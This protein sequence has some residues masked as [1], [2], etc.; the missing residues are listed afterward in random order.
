M[1]KLWLSGLFLLLVVCAVLVF[2]STTQTGLNWIYQLAARTLP[3]SLNIEALEGRLIGPLEFKSLNYRDEQ[4]TVTVDEGR[5]DWRPSMLL[6]RKL[7][8]TTITAEGITYVDTDQREPATDKDIQLPDVS[9]PLDIDVQSLRLSR[10]A[11]RSDSESRIDEITLQAQTDDERLS[12]QAFNLKSETF[13]VNLQGTVTTGDDY[14]LDLDLQWQLNSQS[15]APVS[16]NTLLK[17]SLA[18]LTIQSNMTGMATV[19]MQAAVKNVLTD[20]D[21]NANINIQRLEPNKVQ[22]QWPQTLISGEINTSGNLEAY[23]LAVSLTASETDKAD[24]ELPSITLAASANGNEAELF[25]TALRMA[26]LEGQLEGLG[27]V[28]WSP[29]LLWD[30]Q[31]TAHDINPGVYWDQWP[32]K[33]GMKAQIKGEQSGNTIINNVNLETLDGDLRGYPVHAQGQFVQLGNDLEIEALQAS[34]GSAKLNATGVLKKNWGLRWSLQADDLRAVVPDVRGRLD[35]QG[36]ITGLRQSPRAAFTVVGRDLEVAANRITKLDA[37]VD[38]DLSTG[39]KLLVQVDAANLILAEH[40]WQTSTLTLQG[41]LDKH[42]LRLRLNN[43]A[44]VVAL[45]LNAVMTSNKIWQGVL[46]RADIQ[47]APFGKWQL[48]DSGSFSFGSGQANAGPWCWLQSPSRICITT[49][50]KD[51]AWSGSLDAAALSLAYLQPWLPED[52]R[53][54]GSANAQMNLQYTSSQQVYANAVITTSSG[55][56]EFQ[57][58]DKRQQL[59][60][61]QSTLRINLDQA[62]FTSSITMPLQEIGDIN[63][64][65][66]LPN[67]MLSVGLNERQPIEGEVDIAFS[68]L[69][70]MSLF[71]SDVENVQGDIDGQFKLMGTLG[72]PRIVGSAMLKGGSADIPRLGLQLKE[73]TAEMHGRPDNALRFNMMAKSGD[74]LMRLDGQTV[75]NAKQGWPTE[76]NINGENVEAMDTTE[77]FIAVSP[78]LKIKTQ[79]NLINIEGRIDVPRARIEPREIPKGSVA[80]SPDVVI[81]QA[82]DEKDVADQHQRWA[83]R[84]RVRVVLGDRVNLDGFGLRGK[85]AGDLL[86]IDEPDQLTVGRG[87]MSITDGVYQAYGQ[88][89]SIERGRLIFADSL[90]DDPGLDVRA[91]RTVGDVIAG[92]RVA[93]TLKEPELALFSE[94][95]MAESDILSYLLLGRPMNSASAAEGNVLMAAA[96]SLGLAKGEGLAKSIGATL[97][98]E[99]VRIES[100]NGLQEA[101]L[102]VGRYLSPRLYIRYVT[103]L[104]SVSNTVQLQY[105]LNKRIQIQTES[106]DRTGADIFYKFEH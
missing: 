34:S 59:T 19:S 44:E 2:V 89:L 39:G 4:L 73:I 78:Q 28:A 33:L 88:D 76:L 38:V 90:I 35:A 52:V 80:V 42:N 22:P 65:F 3:G 101:S 24:P 72:N 67:W 51:R 68:S 49:Q 64:R 70:I 103:G 12:I 66:N 47:M 11:I 105:E 26:T 75:L 62:G 87:N 31:L 91:I 84:T 50:Q 56:V 83:L 27:H 100:G 41:S 20:P 97:G 86:V 29:R 13:T 8:L 21:W 55:S 5:I 15:L 43:P 74:G 37:N 58:D 7:L 81:V 63:A 14:P 25:I 79:R 77:I 23:S 95:S 40:A 6:R 45:D 16:G 102:V 60:F 106:G 48:A 17:G 92:V 93:G 98:F 53:I 85:L 10:I 61:D 94:P 36:T 71:T 46:E 30:M 96:G 18:E 54:E 82:V 1:K 9:L 57:G 104:F 69:A 32:G 99:E